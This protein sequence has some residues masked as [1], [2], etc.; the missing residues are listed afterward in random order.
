MTTLVTGAN[1]L[2]GSHVVRLLVQEGREVRAL[3]RAS[4]DLRSLEGVCCERV[5]GDVLDG[6]SLRR[7]LAGCRWVYHVAAVNRLTAGDGETIRRTALEGTRNVLRAAA[8]TGVE[9]VVY[10][11]SIVTAGRAS[12]PGHLLTEEDFT[13]H[14]LTPYVQGKVE[15][16]AWAREFFRES[17]FPL[18]IVNP[19]L[20]LGPGDYRPTPG[21]KLVRDFVAGRPALVIPAGFNVVD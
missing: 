8:E 4:A 13:D 7:A 3:V 19:C 21:G 12:D 5:V 1:G 14:T 9:R 11:S 18:V 10:T 15:A 20:V 16:E 17:S 2:V 6:A